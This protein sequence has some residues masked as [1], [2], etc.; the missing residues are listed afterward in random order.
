MAVI[1]VT[2]TKGDGTVAHEWH[3]ALDYHLRKSAQDHMVI[4]R[5]ISDLKANYDYEAVRASAIRF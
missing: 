4:E 1:N 2:N 3:H 5:L